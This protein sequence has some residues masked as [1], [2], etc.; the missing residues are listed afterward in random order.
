MSLVD[1]DDMTKLRT[2]AESA[3]TAQTAEDEIQLK[4]IAHVI[5]SAANTGLLE[6]LFQE[7]LRPANRT[8]LEE[9]GYTLKPYGEV[10]P[11][12]RTLISWKQS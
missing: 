5:N 2:A 3:E 1:R 9:N 11:D 8:K 6:A 4:A 10:Q 7:E 12:R